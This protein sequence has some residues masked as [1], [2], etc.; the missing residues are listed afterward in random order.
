MTVLVGHV[1]TQ[2]RRHIR[3]RACQ[4]ELTLISPFESLQ[5]CAELILCRRRPP[6][7]SETL[8]QTLFSGVLFGVHRRYFG[9]RSVSLDRSRMQWIIT[10]SSPRP[11]LSAG[12]TALVRLARRRQVPGRQG[13]RPHVCR[14]QSS[15]CGVRVAE[16]SPRTGNREGVKRRRHMPRNPDLPRRERSAPDARSRRPVFGSPGAGRLPLS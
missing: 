16:G 9:R 15:A 4:L 6:R 7:P 1:L 8:A 12:R 5:R 11:S 2:R 10:S 3:S 14:R 13:A